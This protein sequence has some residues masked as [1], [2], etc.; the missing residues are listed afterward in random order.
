MGV[1]ACSPNIILGG[2]S[3]AI[4]AGRCDVRLS[5][6]ILSATSLPSEKPA[7]QKRAAPFEVWLAGRVANEHLVIWLGC[8]TGTMI[9]FTK[10]T[11]R[12]GLLYAARTVR[13]TWAAVAAAHC[14][15]VQ[16]SPPGA[17][18]DNIISSFSPAGVGLTSESRTISLVVSRC[19]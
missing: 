3:P 11:V 17:Y 19:W 2:N 18:F 13:L 9:R 5:C 6:I 1:G 14:R 15:V 12:H 8:A 16:P 10:K 4:R 7:R